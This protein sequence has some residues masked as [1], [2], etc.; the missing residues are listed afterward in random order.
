MSQCVDTALAI[1]GILGGGALDS[2]V[3][4]AARRDAA[5]AEELILLMQLE[6][7]DSSALDAVKLLLQLKR[8]FRVHLAQA[9]APLDH[10][11]SAQ[12]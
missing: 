3:L 2:P 7:N 11:L 6:R 8:E 1:S 4:A 9:E 12:I 10:K 5:A